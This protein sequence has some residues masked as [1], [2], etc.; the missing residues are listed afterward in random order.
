[1]LRVR[2]ALARLRASRAAAPKASLERLCTLAPL[3]A[4]W[5]DDLGLPKDDSH[6]LRWCGDNRTRNVLRILSGLDDLRDAQAWN[7]G[8][9]AAVREDWTASGSRGA[10]IVAGEKGLPRVHTDGNTVISLGLRSAAFVV[11]TAEVDLRGDVSEMSSGVCALQELVRAGV[12]VQDADC[13]VRAGAKLLRLREEIDEDLTAADVLSF[14]IDCAFVS[15][16]REAHCI[17]GCWQG[18]YH[19][20]VT[21]WPLDDA[22]LQD[23]FGVVGRVAA[24]QAFHAAPEYYSLLH[25][26]Q[27]NLMWTFLKGL[28]LDDF[29]GGVYST[30]IV[31]FYDPA[32][33]APAV[34]EHEFT[35]ELVEA[36]LYGGALE[37]VRLSQEDPIVRALLEDWALLSLDL[38]APATGL[39][40]NDRGEGWMLTHH[41]LVDLFSGK[42]EKDGSYPSTLMG[43]VRYALF[44]RD[45]EGVVKKV[46]DKGSFLER[47]VG[48]L[49][50]AT[51]ARDAACESDAARDAAR[52]YDATCAR[53]LGSPYAPPLPDD[54]AIEAARRVA[55]D[56]ATAEAARVEAV[57]A[58]GGTG[59]SLR[60]KA[61]PR[62]WKATD[63]VPPEAG[64]TTHFICVQWD[65]VQRFW[66]ATYW[67]GK[68]KKHV[69]GTYPTNQR[70][71]RA[72]YECIIAEDLEQFND[73][74]ALD[75]ATDLMV[76]REKKRR[77]EEPVAAA[78]TRQS[79]RVRRAVSRD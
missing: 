27:Q 49:L 52:R 11:D 23:D 72:R 51:A 47:D 76:P 12:L 48:T 46:L 20:M 2:A 60:R 29:F 8:C 65:S 71:A 77:R 9:G 22:A 41:A 45:A 63:V 17:P 21:A 74:D 14:W 28:A 33:G 50:R 58:R 19:W 3:G 18:V 53:W 75:E 54:A 34:R 57:R 1:M 16:R 43:G 39:R 38:E 40:C 15:G 32:T 5:L 64:A 59:G 79:S 13:K 69:P 56:R 62:T 25:I 4:R 30:L 78:P 35:R 61:A 42:F 10:A 67:R 73:M 7:A 24:L 26:R 36:I 37:R 6:L 44:A 55:A 31:R 66:K 68:E 70:A